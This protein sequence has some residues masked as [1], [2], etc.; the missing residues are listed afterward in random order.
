MLAVY[1]ERAAPRHVYTRER[2]GGD[3]GAPDGP[4]VFVEVE[5]RDAARDGTALPAPC[6]RA[7]AGV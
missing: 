6:T 3:G 2:S 5:L 4:D 1:G 7:D